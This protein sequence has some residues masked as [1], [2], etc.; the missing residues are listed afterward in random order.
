MSAYVSFLA[1][2]FVK[3]LHSFQSFL[4]LRSADKQEWT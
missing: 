4:D 2:K 1:K 3:N